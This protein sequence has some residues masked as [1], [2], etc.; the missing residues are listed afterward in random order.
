[1]YWKM[2]SSMCE[3]IFMRLCNQLY[4][5]D[6]ILI[7]ILFNNGSSW[8]KWKCNVV[9]VVLWILK[10]GHRV[11]P[12]ILT[13]NLI[14]DVNLTNRLYLPNI[15]RKHWC[16]QYHLGSQTFALNWFVIVQ[17]CNRQPSQMSYK[18]SMIKRLIECFAFARGIIC[19]PKSDD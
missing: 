6:E 1:M 14:V 8:M 16:V 11:H 10:W 17:F 12:L 13:I 3:Q 5:S 2:K 9:R 7:N 4:P 19:F 18:I 15:P